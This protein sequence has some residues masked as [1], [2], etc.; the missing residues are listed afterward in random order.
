MDQVTVQ[1]DLCSVVIGSRKY[2]KSEFIGFKLWYFLFCWR[3]A[4]TDIVL[5]KQSLFAQWFFLALL[6]ITAFGLNETKYHFQ[7]FTHSFIVKEIATSK[8]EQLQFSAML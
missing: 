3:E 2:Y 1:Y 4:M 7:D 8:R 6:W 5:E